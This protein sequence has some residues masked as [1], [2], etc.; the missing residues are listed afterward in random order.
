MPNPINTEDHESVGRWTLDGKELFFS[1]VTDG[2]EDLY[3]GQLDSI[4]HHWKISPFT[5]N[6]SSNEG[7][8]TIS[9]DGKIPGVYSMQPTRWVWELRLVCFSSKKRYLDQTG[10]H[11]SGI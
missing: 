8:P 2:Q 11:G 5:F 7:A 9:P 10:E 6:T 4:T 1:R 3:I